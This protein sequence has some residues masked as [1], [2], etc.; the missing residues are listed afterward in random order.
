MKESRKL[1][2]GDI[3]FSFSW[4]NIIMMKNFD[5]LVFQDY[6]KIYFA[7]PPN[8]NSYISAI[9]LTILFS[10]AIYLILFVFRRNHNKAILAFIYVLFASSLLIVAGFVRESFS[11]GQI[12]FN[13]Y[14]S[15]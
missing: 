10:I 3:L 14:K 5:W 1:L 13:D 2:L 11:I 9:C 8:L 7:S 6:N 12:F 4:S 15:T